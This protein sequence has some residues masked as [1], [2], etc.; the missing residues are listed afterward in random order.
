MDNSTFPLALIPLLPLTGAAVNLLL[1]KR[2]GKASGLVGVMSVALAAVFAWTAAIRLFTGPED[3]VLRDTLF[4]GDWIRASELVAEQGVK[5]G[6]GLMLD[7]LSG[8]MILIITTIGTLIHIYSTA[9]MEHDEGISRY[10]GYL[11]LFTGSMLILVLGDS[12][13][14]TFVGWE[15]VGLCS[16]LLIG[17]WYGKDANAYAGRK[18]FIVN[19]VGDFGFL[20]GIFFVFLATNTL[21]YTELA[22]NHEGLT[23]TF[24]GL[25]FAT[26]AG[27]LLFVGATG[28]SAQLPLYVWLPDAMAG[29]TPVSALI[30]A[31]TMVTAGVYMIARLNFLFSL[32]PTAQAVIA[33]VGALTALFAATM[34]VTARPIKKILAYSTVS[35]LGFMFIGVG[36]GAYAAGVFHLFTHA[37]FKAGLFLA[38]GSIMHALG[39]E[40]DV[41]KMGGLRKRLPITHASYLVYCLAIAGIPP[42]AGFFSKDAILAGAF[43]FHGGP[44]GLGTVIYLVGLVAAACTAFYMFRSYFL[45]FSGEYRG[46]EHTWEHSHESPPAMSYVLAA[47][48]VGSALVGFLGVPHV[49]GGSDHF[50]HWLKPVL[51]GHD[52]EALEGAIE[53]AE[54]GLSAAT[55]F[56]MMGAAIFVSLGGIGLAWVLYGKGIS[57]TAERLATSAG[58]LHRLVSNKYYVDEIYDFLV[59]RPLRQV[60]IFLSKVID[61]VVIDRILVLGWARVVDITGGLVRYLHNGDVQ[62]AVVGVAIGTAAILSVGAN[63]TAWQAAHFSVRARGPAEIQVDARG[64]PT[65]VGRELDYT[66]DFHEGEGSVIK[67]KVPSA[68][69]RFKNEGTHKIT[70]EVTDPRWH[71]SSRRTETLELKGSAQ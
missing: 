55:E 12:L 60:G 57:P 3:L 36:T 63:M 54:A 62:T 22:K 5:I 44:H 32:S 41:M 20:L 10:F 64:V 11:N 2:L 14:L 29:P 8:L 26:V 65:Q 25:T 17:F 71:T 59:V 48:A 70:V 30:H 50:A 1:G 21:D 19:R 15:G 9:Y 28:K 18:A 13:A 56:A 58:G 37:V 42:F 68:Y 24:H 66:F 38:A 7:H 61:A 31:A 6:A 47:L 39:N 45:V 49:L 23:A 40:E 16:Y 4:H 52:T 46:D 51:E 43:E 34:G 67:Q 69:Y 33:S 27:L 35:Q 53:H